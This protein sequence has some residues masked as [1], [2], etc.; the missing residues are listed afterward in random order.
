MSYKENMIPIRQGNINL[1]SGTYGTGGYI[2]QE[3]GVLTITWLDTTTEN[4]NLVA[5]DAVDFS[6]VDCES[7]TIVSGSFIKA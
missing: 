6:S 4:L 3:D 7:I 1:T 2:C 5:G